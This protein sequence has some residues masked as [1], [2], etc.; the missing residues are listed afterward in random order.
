MNVDEQLLDEEEGNKLQPYYDHLGFATVARGRLIDPRKPCPIPQ[1]VAD[2][3]N[4]DALASARRDAAR[5]PGWAA[6]NEVQKAVLVSMVY[7]LGLAPFDGDGIRDWKNFVAAMRVGNF[8][9]AAK[10]GRDSLWW[11]EQ[12]RARAERQMRMLE[13][14]LWVPWGATRK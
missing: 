9:Q 2:L 11:R 10:E 14:G 7:Q 8:V 12:T 5:V 1:S 13:S 6:C 4:A 3:L